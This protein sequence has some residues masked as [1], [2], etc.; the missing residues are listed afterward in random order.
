[1]RTLPLNCN[2]IKLIKAIKRSLISELDWENAG[3]RVQKY[4]VQG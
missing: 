2:I 3:F 4:R 1:M